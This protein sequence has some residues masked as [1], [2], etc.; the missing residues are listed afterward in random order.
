MGVVGLAAMPKSVGLLSSRLCVEQV[1]DFLMCQKEN[2]FWGRVVGA[3]SMQR[4][5]MDRCLDDEVLCALD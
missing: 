4:D 1:Q 3:C 2:G 5:L